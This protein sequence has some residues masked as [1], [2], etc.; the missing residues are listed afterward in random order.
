[1]DANVCG[2]GLFKLRL[3]EEQCLTHMTW[4]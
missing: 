2:I 1:V 3:M 4:S